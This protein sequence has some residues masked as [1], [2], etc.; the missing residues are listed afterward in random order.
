MYPEMVYLAM[1][2]GKEELLVIFARKPKMTS[3]NG[4]VLWP[5][6]EGHLVIIINDVFGLF[7]P[8]ILFITCPLASVPAALLDTLLRRLP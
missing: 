4:A 5:V 8:L 7:V 1:R 3:L 2:L 6:D